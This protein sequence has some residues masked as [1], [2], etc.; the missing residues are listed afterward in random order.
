MTDARHRDDALRAVLDLLPQPCVVHLRGTVLFANRAHQQLL[1]WTTLDDLVGR[2]A[3][4]CVHPDDRDYVRARVASTAQNRRTAE[5]RLVSGAGEAIPVEVS[6][7]PFPFEGAVASLALVH[8]LRERK[9]VDAELAAAERLASLG[10]LAS[11]VGHE[12]NNPLTYVLGSLALLERE[13]A[14]QPDLRA[15]V[16]A[17]LE[18][19]TRVR[20]IVRDLRAMSSPCDVPAGPV[21]LRRVLDRAV[22]TA[23][24]EIEHR[25]R[26]VRDD[27]ELPPVAGSE[28]RLIQVFVNLL[29]N[30][31]HAIPDGAALDNEIRVVT[32]VQGED[33]VVV[34]VSDTGHG[35][36]AGDRERLFEPFFTT[37]S[38]TGSGLGLSIVHRI[39]MQSG[40]TIEAE[41]CEPR[42]ACFRVT[43][44]AEPRAPEPAVLSPGRGVP[45]RRGRV[46]FIDDEPQIRLLARD[47]LAPHDVVTATSGR[48]AIELLASREFDAIVCDLQMPDLGGVDVYDWLLAR[49]PDLAHR[50]VFT[51]GGAFTDRAHD[52]IATSSL[53]H[54]EKPF[55]IER[56][57]AVVDALLD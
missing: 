53:P 37:K 45:R 55:D 12:I 4:E 54:L 57:R 49:R 13:L 39:V 2:D 35:I 14:G 24:H 18:G 47:I 29:V 3:L 21:D 26:L 15:R 51:T 32:R 52:F 23:M 10:R 1:G 22:A 42:G 56:M 25:A 5:H 48:D 44:R 50:I 34:E 31:A 19:A 30:A 27:V 16:D 20:D 43:L 17:A 8:D 46:L 36:A 6:G 38:G 9:R 41:P 28:G 7:I 33:R 11:A 40:G